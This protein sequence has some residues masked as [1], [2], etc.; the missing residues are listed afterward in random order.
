MKPGEPWYEL[1]E[2][3]RK[4]HSKSSIIKRED[5]VPG[6]SKPVTGNIL[7]IGIP[8][9]TK[10]T[11][12]RRRGE[13]LFEIGHKILILYD[14]GDRMD[15]CYLMFPSKHL[16]WKIP[17][18]RKKRNGGYEIIGKRSYPVEVLIPITKNIPKGRNELPSNFIPF[19]IPV[20]DLDRDDLIA[21]TGKRAMDMISGAYSYMEEKVDEDTTGDDY[22]NLLERAISKKAK[23]EEKLTHYGP[24][25]LIERIF[26]P[27]NNQGLLSNKKVSCAID[28]KEHIMNRKVITV[29]CLRHCPPQFHGFVVHY[30]MNHISQILSGRGTTKKIKQKTTI[31]LNEV[32]ILLS[33]DEEE[34]SSADAI[35]RKIESILKMHRTS[36][37]FLCMDTQLID[38][39]PKVKETL[40]QIKVFASSMASIQKAMEIIGIT[41]KSG[42]I[43]E[44]SYQL[45]P[46]LPKGWYYLFDRNKGVSMHKL[47]WCRSRTYLDGENFYDIYR[48][49]YGA[50]LGKL[51]YQ[52]INPLLVELKNQKERSKEMWKYREKIER[53]PVV[54]EEKEVPERKRDYE[55]FMKTR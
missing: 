34:G 55:A 11:A 18:I 36:S 1:F 41:E 40:Q 26:R 9:S 52:D 33:K 38:D 53:K 32:H 51:A 17:K 29:L 20:C 30:L 39:L 45:I 47:K 25:R 50:K 7:N 13:I 15:I 35:S 22:I 16:Y 27:L 4:R 3:E 23:K 42:Q 14:G 12:N 49:V 43:T 46:H 8:G 48:E 24:R 44:D 54:K 19:T 2:K 10:S 5:F 31:I 28:L 21:L 6:G 37:T